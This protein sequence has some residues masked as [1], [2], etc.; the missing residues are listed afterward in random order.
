MIRSP[1]I[2]V[3][4]H[5]D[6][7]KTAIL[8]SIRGSTV[9]EGEPGKIT[10]HVGASFIPT[11]TVEKQSKEII[12]KYGYKLEIPGLLFIDTP[13]HQAFTSLRKRGG[14]TADLAVLVIDVMQGIQPQTKEALEILKKH[15]CP[16]II[17]L[18]K[19]DLIQGWTPNKG[20]PFTKTIKKQSERVKNR[21][22][23]KIYDII[24]EVAE[25]GINA[26]RFDKVD[27]PEDTIIIIPTSAETKEG[28]PELLMFLA[29]LSQRY[30][31]KDLEVEK[32][33]TG[34]GT[35]LEVKEVKGLGTTIDTIIYEGKIEKGD[36]IVFG[37]KNGAKETK[38]RALLKP[39]KLKEMREAKGKDFKRVKK[40]EAAEGIKIA[41][42]GLEEAIAGSPVIIANEKTEEKKKEVEEQLE[43]VT[44]KNKGEGVII[45]ADTIG[46]LEGI[47]DLFKEKEIPIRRAEIGQVRK[48]DLTEAKTIKEKDRYL[49]AI[50]AFNTKIPEEIEKKAEELNVPIF[51]SNI[52]YK[53]E[54]KYQ[55][56][57][58]KEE[59][60]E[61]QERL[62][63]YVY[64]AKIKILPEHTF[65]KSKPAIVGIKLQQGK[66]KPGYPLM[67]KEGERLGEIKSIQK[68]QHS[69]KLLEQGGEAAI[70]ITDVT[71]GRQ[72]EEGE[73]IYTEVPV[74]ETYELEREGFKNKQLLK[75]IRK[76]KR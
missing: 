37:T 29:G 20:Q 21:L 41:A 43:K 74:D 71:V 15:K 5:V 38:I 7:G 73:T 36:K 48:K 19:V 47:I 3:L 9:L 17:A 64:P 30:M 22:Q 6:H 1:I 49:G 32:E 40:V 62:E 44:I 2:C 27:N 31:K 69:I 26:N 35:I 76:I 50:F 59:K 24:G 68:D 11:Q 72:I 54:E 51:E 57:K 10:Q 65:R 67:N 13:G 45:R 58:E 61:K 55:K 39:K 53:L 60:R 66:L 33:K 16:F 75:E 4:G 23:D 12:E 8:D 56:W 70:A 34:E 46:S 25:Y 42:P 63:K 14:K 28:I 52:I 18:N